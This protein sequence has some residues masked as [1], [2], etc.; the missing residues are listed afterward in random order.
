MEALCTCPLQTAASVDSDTDKVWQLKEDELNSDASQTLCNPLRG[1]QC[2]L[3]RRIYDPKPRAL[4]V[5]QRPHRQIHIKTLAG[6]LIL[7]EHFL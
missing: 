3:P 6:K 2:H 7:E 5:S 1:P 4:F